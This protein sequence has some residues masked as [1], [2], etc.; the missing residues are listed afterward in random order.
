MPTVLISIVNEVQ[1]DLNEF[2]VPETLLKK[3]NAIFNSNRIAEV[4]RDKHRTNE[5]LTSEGILMPS[6]ELKT[7]KKVFSNERVGSERRSRFRKHRRG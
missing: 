5:K 7:G 6:L 3:V 2:N 1:D 4:I